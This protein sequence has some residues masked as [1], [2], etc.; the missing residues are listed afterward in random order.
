M[1]DE[2]K[3]KKYCENSGYSYRYFGEN[4]V[5]MTSVDNW[6][7]IEVENPPNNKN[8]KNK[9]KIIV[10]HA[11][12][13]GNKTGKMQFHTQRIAYDVDWIFENIIIPH[14]SYNRAFQ[15]TFKVKKLLKTV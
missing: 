4:V 5:I 6:Q 14:Q 3:I 13:T 10:E 8:N 1:L 15:K 7:L 11:N 12:K 2:M 9:Y